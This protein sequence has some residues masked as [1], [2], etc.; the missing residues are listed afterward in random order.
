MQIRGI[1]ACTLEI[2]DICDNPNPVRAFNKVIRDQKQLT[3][4]FATD[5]CPQGAEFLVTEGRRHSG[6]DGAPIPVFVLIGKRPVLDVDERHCAPEIDAERG[7]HCTTVCL[8][9]CIVLGKCT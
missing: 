3:A 8:S 1:T 4:N 5:T 9:D 6:G 7:N 2:L